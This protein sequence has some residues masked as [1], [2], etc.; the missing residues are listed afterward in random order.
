MGKVAQG[1][2]SWQ[3]G[4]HRLWLAWRLLPEVLGVKRV[5][6]ICKGSSGRRAE[7]GQLGFQALTASPA[8]FSLSP[9]LPEHTGKLVGQ[10]TESHCT[11]FHSLRAA[12]PGKK[13]RPGGGGG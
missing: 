11:K 4:P 1:T 7:M 5:G 9:T 2:S 10:N 6:V 8:S 13:G 12:S 3:L